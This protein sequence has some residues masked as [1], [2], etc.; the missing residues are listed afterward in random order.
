MTLACGSHG[1]EAGIA[2][3]MITIGAVFYLR[4]RCVSRRRQVADSRA[5]IERAFAEMDALDAR[6]ALEG[7]YRV[8]MSALST[9]LPSWAA[10]M[11]IERIADRES[12][13]RR[14]FLKLLRD[15]DIVEE[16]ERLVEIAKD[17]TDPLAAD[18]WS[19]LTGRPA[20][21]WTKAL[22]AS[23][24]GQDERTFLESKRDDA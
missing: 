11:A 18:V 23:D 7:E 2:L 24:G 4:L 17:S 15:A 19:L 3:L 13:S 5:P 6:E 1:F 21:E 12:P 20:G 14:R 8:P 9:P 22:V 10:A 16:R